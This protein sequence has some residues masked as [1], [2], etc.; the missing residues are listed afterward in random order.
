MKASRHNTLTWTAKIVSGCKERHFS[1]ALGDF[2]EMGRVWVKKDSFTFSSVLKAC[3]RM[4]NHGSC[5]EQV[6][7]DTI[8]LGF[9]SDSYVQCSLIAMYGRTVNAE[10]I[11]EP[12][13]NVK[14]QTS[15]SFPGCTD[16]LTL[17]GTGFREKVF[18]II[19]VKVYAAGLYLNQSIVTDLKGWKWKSKDVIQGTSSLF[20][21]IFQ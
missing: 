20:N 13:T 14:F 12:A 21:T 4:Q 19:G 1:E 17:F 8:K 7:A 9:D 10:Y 16:S 6:H 18:A 15:S 3:G 11:E 2:K 5:G